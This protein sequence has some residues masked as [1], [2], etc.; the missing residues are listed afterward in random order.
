MAK[1]WWEIEAP[2][3][4]PE[5]LEHERPADCFECAHWNGNG[6]VGDGTWGV[7]ERTMRC[8]SAWEDPSEH[9]REY[10]WRMG[11]EDALSRITSGEEN[12]CDGW[13]EA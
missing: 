5:R 7:C 13:S 2:V 9:S 8:P 11:V 3:D 1:Q 12:A 10:W 6:A 4:P